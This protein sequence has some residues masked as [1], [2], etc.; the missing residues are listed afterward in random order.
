MKS[1]DIAKARDFSVQHSQ[2]RQ[3]TATARFSA[4]NLCSAGG[5]LIDGVSDAAVCLAIIMQGINIV[6]NTSGSLSARRGAYNG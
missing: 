4:A 3:R 5:A 1:T 2:T 6:V